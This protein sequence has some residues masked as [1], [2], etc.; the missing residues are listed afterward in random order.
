ML[1]TSIIQG[2]QFDIVQGDLNKDIKA[3]AYDSRNVT[4]DGIFVAI[5]GAQ[6]AAE[7]DQPA[8]RCF[9]HFRPPD[10]GDSWNKPPISPANRRQA[11][12][13]GGGQVKRSCSSRVGCLKLRLQAHRAICWPGLPPP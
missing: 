4:K 1:L 2:M 8:S 12:A 6:N 9:L 3:I 5:S 10:Y 7:K 13:S 11:P